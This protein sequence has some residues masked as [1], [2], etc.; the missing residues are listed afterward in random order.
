[1]VR[2]IQNPSKFHFAPKVLIPMFLEEVMVKTFL[3]PGVQIDS[4][5]D[6]LMIFEEPFKTNLSLLRKVDD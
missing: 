1:M 5:Y 6:R 3:E 2:V 4:T